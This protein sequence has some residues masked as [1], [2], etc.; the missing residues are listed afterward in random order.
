M[1]VDDTS[2]ALAQPQGTQAIAAALGYGLPPP[3]RHADASPLHIDLCSP[4]P[5]VPPWPAAA[6]TGLST[7]QALAAR[8]G[9][10][11]G[12]EAACA[13]PPFIDLTVDDVMCVVLS[14]S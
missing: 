9:S 13:A 4:P 11:R 8:D 1:R 3:P 14:S 5:P 6:Q 12:G 10:S 2:T 7:R